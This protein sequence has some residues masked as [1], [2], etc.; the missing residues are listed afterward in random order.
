MLNRETF[1]TDPSVYRLANQGVAKISFPPTPE[2]LETLRGE[3]STFVCDGAYANGLA[4]ILEAYLGSVG[5]SGGAPAVW[6]SGF[7]GSGK[8][9]LFFQQV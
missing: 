4:R 2:A 1:Q 8:S 3:I 7:Y 9:H 6:I 5:K